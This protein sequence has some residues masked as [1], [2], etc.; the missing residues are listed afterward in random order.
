MRR[1]SLS[2]GNRS[3]SSDTITKNH[4]LTGLTRLSLTIP[5]QLKQWTLFAYAHTLVG[6]RGMLNV[7]WTIGIGIGIGPMY[8]EYLGAFFQLLHMYVR[9]TICRLRLSPRVSRKQQSHNRG[10][11]VRVGQ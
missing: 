2:F 11:P 10:V 4:R 6:C 8:N 3:E 7:S 1:S 9:S 5:C